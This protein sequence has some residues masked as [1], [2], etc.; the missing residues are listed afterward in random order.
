MTP[1]EFPV[2]KGGYVTPMDDSNTKN[3]N[4]FGYESSDLR[5]KRKNAYESSDYEAPQAPKRIVN[6]YESSGFRGKGQEREQDH[7]A[8]DRGNS[9]CAEKRDIS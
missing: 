4:V 8:L 9:I 7:W 1:R 5:P 2:Q 6:A 3:N